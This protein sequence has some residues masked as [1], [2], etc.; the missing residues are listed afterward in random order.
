MYISVVN[1]SLVLPINGCNFYINL[2]V[3]FL[4]FSRCE[5]AGGLC[6]ALQLSLFHF[7]F[8]SVTDGCLLTYFP[9]FSTVTSLYWLYK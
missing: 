7:V 1:L 3:M 9:P 6:G 8:R 4:T 5:G 2:I